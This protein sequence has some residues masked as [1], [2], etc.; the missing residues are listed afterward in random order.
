MAL[1]KKTFEF[2]KLSQTAG[3]VIVQT[4]PARK[5]RYIRVTSLDYLPA[6]TA[7]Q[8]TSM[9]VRATTSLSIA[10]AAGLTS[11]VLVDDLNTLGVTVM[12]GDYICIQ[13]PDNVRTFTTTVSSYTAGTK[14][15]VIV[16]NTP[17]GG[18]AAG[19]AVWYLGAPADHTGRH[20]D[21][22]ASTYLSRRA[23]IYDGIFS[24]PNKYEPMILYS[25]NGTNA[26]AFDL[27]NGI[28][29]EA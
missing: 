7:H 17:T 24:T 18:L 25:P 16:D 29:A 4:I 15:L 27:I 23:S 28:Y 1:F 21:T 11:L 13:Y 20:L 8:L 3:T 6:A 22:V 26:G 5:N 10:Y 9:V 12:A 14:T 2:F 19:A